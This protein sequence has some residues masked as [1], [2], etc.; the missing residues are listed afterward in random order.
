MLNFSLI[1][2]FILV[3][4]VIVFVHELGHFL[5]AKMVGVD[6][7]EFGFGYPPRL[8]K[9]FTRKGTEFTLN[10]IPF[11]GFVRLKGETD[12]G[13]PGGML[14][15]PK[16]KRFLILIGGATM[17]FVLG[18]LLLI[19]LYNVVNP[20]DPSKVM[21]VEVAPNS[22][23]QVI[24]LQPGDIVTRLGDNEIDSSDAMVN[25]TKKYL[26]QEVTL[27][28]IRDGVEL[29]SIVTPR[30]NP[31]EGQGAIGFVMSHPEVELNFGQTIG[32]AFDTFW[33]QVK[34]TVAL[35]YNF[36]KGKLAPGEARVIGIKGIYDLFSN[37]AEI[38]QTNAEATNEV[39]PITRLSLVSMLSIAIGI[40]NLLPIPALDGGQIFFL[41]I[42]AVTRKRIPARIAN[43][44][45]SAFF[46]I[47]ILLFF[48]ITIRDFINPIPIP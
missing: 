26:D 5:L 14:S 20:V 4:G 29:K 10:W 13:E 37:A 39:L 15:A 12:D 32:V 1:L 3:F 47:L 31:P 41:L 42:E 23:A 11:G 8:V 19:F 45:N 35:P 38:D 30:A 46:Y 40:T 44:V 27:A 34:A 17:N 25:A 7:E 36:I 33:Q 28:Y 6:V 22:P 48:V 2:Q 9:L 24:G 43:A 21:V 16:W 18:I